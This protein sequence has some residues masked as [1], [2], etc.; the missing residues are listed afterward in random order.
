[1]CLF[2][3]AKCFKVFA[4][5]NLFDLIL[6]DHSHPQYPGYSH[7]LSLKIKNK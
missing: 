4:L 5:G 2:V 3:V 6:W 1:M 7:F